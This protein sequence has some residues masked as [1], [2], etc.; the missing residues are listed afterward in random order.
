MQYLSMGDLRL[1]HRVL[2]EVFADDPEP[3]P[4]WEEGSLALLETCRGSIEVQAFGELKYPD[5]PSCV[6]KL[7][8]STIKSHAFP[9]GNK[10]FALVLALLF[11][12]KN[13]NWLTAPEGM[14]AEIATWVAE[15]DP[16]DPEHAPDLVIGTLTEF[17]RNNLGIYADPL[18]KRGG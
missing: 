11:I 17:Y 5:L 7:F 12:R 4:A 13:G 14:G 15:S 9:N 1:A 3:I 18:P 10:R 8:Y 2:A 16:H 6:A